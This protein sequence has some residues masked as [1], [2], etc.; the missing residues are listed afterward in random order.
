MKEFDWIESQ[1]HEN[2]GMIAQQLQTIMPELV[3]EDLSNGTLSI[4]TTKFIPYLIK[5]I[6][7]LTEYI[8]G[9]IS[10]M[11]FKDQWSDPYA[12][13]EKLQFIESIKNSQTNTIIEKEPILL[14]IDTKGEEI[15]E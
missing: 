3:H 7:E 10:L 13:S 6:Q 1:E 11:S 2:I 8:T 9:G 4:K 14:P 15:N 12:E 5:A